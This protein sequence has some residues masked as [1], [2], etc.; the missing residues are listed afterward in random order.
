[1]EMKKKH[2]TGM[3]NSFKEETMKYL[4]KKSV[5]AACSLAF[6]GFAAGQAQ[7]LS[8]EVYQVG[9]EDAL[10]DAWLGSD[11]TIVED[12]EDS[13]LGW[14]QS[15]LTDVGEFTITDNTLPGT[16]STSYLQ[17]EGGEGAYFEVRDNGIS[18]RFDGTKYLDSADITE[19]TLNVEGDFNNLFFYLSD[20][21]DIYALTLTSGETVSGATFAAAELNYPEPDGSKW[22]I[23]IDV[24]N[25]D[26][27][28]S[29]TWTTTLDGSPYTNDGYGLDDFGRK[30]VPEPATALLIGAGLLPLVGLRR[31]KK[32]NK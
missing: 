2:Q 19:L 32:R 8:V 4:T 22:F 9:T 25:N 16:G 1:M 21:S 3:K 13:E 23:G 20:P 18:G 14:Y 5:M 12:F 10:I 30:S 27:I 6:L 17:R 7:A 15:L 11:Y 29:I 28:A 31:R 26:T 24:G